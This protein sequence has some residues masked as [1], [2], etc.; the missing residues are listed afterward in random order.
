[1]K[2]INRRLWGWLVGMAGGN[3]VQQRESEFV[4]G[5][6]DGEQINRRLWGWLVGMAGGN[7]VQRESGFVAG[8]DDGER[9]TANPLPLHHP[10]SVDNSHSSHASQRGVLARLCVLCVLWGEYLSGSFRATKLS[11]ATKGLA[12]LVVASVL[13]PVSAAAQQAQQAD[14]P[15]KPVYDKW[16][17]G[18][19]GVE[20]RGDGP[21]AAYMLPRPRDFT[22]A[23]YQIR[24]TTSG[25]LPTDADMMRVI[26]EGMPGTAMPGWRTVLGEQDR[27]NLVAYL[28]T[29]SRFFETDQP[30]VIEFSRAPGSNAETLET[31]AQVYQQ[32]ECFKCHG[33]AGRGDGQSAPT[34]EDNHGFPIRPADLTEPWYFNGGGAVE[35]IFRRFRTGL[36]GTPMPSYSDVLDAG[37]VTEEQMWA[38]AHYV[39]SL[40]GETPAVREV[41]RADRVEGALPASVDDEAWAAVERFYIPLVGQIIVKPRW[42][43]PMV[44]GVWIQ[45]QHDGNE[46]VVRV[47]WSDPS[48]SPAAEWADWRRLVSQSMEPK[49]DVAAPVAEA[50]A[51]GPADASGDAIGT[52]PAQSADLPDALMLQFPRTIPSGMERP[53]FF[54]GSAREPVYAW[55]WQSRGAAI[56]EML[57]RGPGRLDP[58][59]ASNGLTAEATFDQGRWRVLF[60]R[61]LA[62]QDTAN[63]LT[64]ATGQAIPMAIF[65]WD[66]DNTEHGLRGAISTWYFIYLAEPVPGTLYATPILAM[67][68]TAGLGLFAVGR[69]QKRERESGA[70][71]GSAQ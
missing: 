39:K 15:G 53:Y 60:R 63:A 68:L 32:M 49:D 26:D 51:S 22:Q 34:Q 10:S 47:S 37:V 52:A 9:T 21:A 50:A 40:G 24:T 23:L 3:R 43:A 57:A 19:H 13:S 6:D 36:D 44:D 71:A 67:L 12:T 25:S 45:A 61:S 30:Q 16:C 14:H 56:T 11:L 28:K 17:A 69:A 70:N 46:L 8:M 62:A 5:M 54:M 48:N 35:D 58:A 59:P 64:F 55:R 20:G 18:C 2:Q 29:F 42:F 38:L 41:V 33:Q 27:R 7:S 65:A 4:L 31:G 1:M 66:G